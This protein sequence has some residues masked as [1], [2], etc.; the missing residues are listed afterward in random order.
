MIW[1]SFL[2][3]VQNIAL[4]LSIALVYDVAF[5]RRDVGEELS[6]RSLLVQSLFGLVVGAVGVAI[7]STPWILVPGIV[8]D[9]RSVMLGISGLFFGTVPTLI[10]MA[11]AAAYRLYL[12]GGGTLMGICVIVA[13]GS[14]GILWRHLRKGR[15]ESISW[16][17]IYAFG[18]V[19]HA[20]MLALI[21]TLPRGSIAQAFSSMT[22]PVIV[23]YP[24][25]TAFLGV[26]LRNRLRRRAGEEKLRLSETRLKSTQSLGRIG[27]WEWD[28]VAG[29]THWSDEV[30]HIHGI[31]VGAVED[32][33]PELIEKSLACFSGEDRLKIEGAFRECAAKGTPY[34]LQ[35]PFTDF[36]GRELWVRTV[37]YGIWERGRV[38]RVLGY[39]MDITGIHEAEERI[40]AALREKETLLR[41]LYHRTKNNMQVISSMLELRAESVGS[42]ESRAALLDIGT[43]VAAMALV[44]QMLYREKDLSHI[45][46]DEYVRELAD[47]LGSSYAA[48]PGRVRLRLDL[49]PATVLIDVAMPCGLILS[50]LVSNS[51]KHAF[52]GDRRGEIAIRLS[53]PSPEEMELEVADDGVGVVTDFDFRHQSSLGLQTIFALAEHQLQGRI[54]FATEGGLV[55]RF[56]FANRHYMERV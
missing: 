10:A 29:K 21:L 20:I 56:R 1:T 52:P 5:P 50:E 28:A 35:A 53:R 30:F 36:Q 27:G 3:L 16:L 55:C 46:L 2:G 17:E 25:G 22:L 39:I 38:A 31:P 54:S 4:L 44:H 11:I 23:I 7:M 40:A 37:A 45:R 19:I 15:L 6:G 47:L 48:S 43:R 42:V 14:I 32:G 24:G 18:L 51:L 34:D 9:T 13:T 8:F 33:S 49:E 12:G 26:L 41:E